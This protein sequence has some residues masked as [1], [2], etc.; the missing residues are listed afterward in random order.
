LQEA[1]LLFE[2]RAFSFNIIFAPNKF[3]LDN[4]K[5][6]KPILKNDYSAEDSSPYR[7]KFNFENFKRKKA[8]DE[9]Q[10]FWC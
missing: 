2:Q 7:T 6:F 4:N 8:R 5:Y 1:S 3:Q 10:I 9:V